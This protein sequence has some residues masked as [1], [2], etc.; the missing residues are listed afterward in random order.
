MT[1][2]LV[3]N[4]APALEALRRQVSDTVLTILMPISILYT[5]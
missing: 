2:L 3:E 1:I 4:A 5:K